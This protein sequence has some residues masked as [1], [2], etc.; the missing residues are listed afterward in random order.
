MIVLLLACIPELTTP[1]G[2][3]AGSNAC[4]DE[5]L[6]NSWPIAEV[7]ADVVAEGFGIGEV[8][9]RACLPDQE[10]NDVDTWQFHGRWVVF[11][12]STIWCAPCQVLAAGVAETV[13]DYGGGGDFTYMTILAEDLEAEVPDTDEL[14]DWATGFG[15]EQPVLA[16]TAEYTT[17]LT[18][19]AFPAVLLLDPELRVVESGLVADELVRAA[20]DEHVE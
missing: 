15:I 13:A 18:G 6:E 20:L 16:D 9:P 14:L 7:P 5:P 1:A 3:G 11:D 10:G 17:D 8:I 12:V 2:A 19:G 4:G